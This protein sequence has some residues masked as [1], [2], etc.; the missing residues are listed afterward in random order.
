M[1]FQIN[2]SQLK[3]EQTSR[4]LPEG[5]Y[6]FEVLS[7][8]EKDNAKS[9][10]GKMFAIKLAVI[11]G[12]GKRH[13]VKD[14]L[15][16][17]NYGLLKIQ[18]L[19]ESVGLEEAFATGTLEASDLLGATGT[20]HTGIG[21]YNGKPQV[22][23]KWYVPEPNHGYGKVKPAPVAARVAVPVVVDPNDLPF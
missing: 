16:A 7:A 13:L 10:N 5:D 8:E 15:G 9:A 1:A 14:W 18:A 4:I 22:N 17:W 21:E 23:V 20:V 6:P 12:D 19:C 11:D 2:H 3:D